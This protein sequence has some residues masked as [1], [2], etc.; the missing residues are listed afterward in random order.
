MHAGL[1]AR[2]VTGEHR[3]VHGCRHVGVVKDDRGCLAAQFSRNLNQIAPCRRSNA[4]AG[5]RSTGQIDLGQ[6]LVLGQRLARNGAEPM[7]HVD[8]AVRH[9]AVADQFREH[10]D[11]QRSQFGGFDHNRVARGQRRSQFLG[12][13]QQRVV[14]RGQQSDNSEGLPPGV[15]QIAAPK[16]RQSVFQHPR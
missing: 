9:A 2:D 15:V 16:R 10:V 1:A 6:G 5:L 11:R 14:P 12:E 13:D 8:D 3:A 4:P 7:D